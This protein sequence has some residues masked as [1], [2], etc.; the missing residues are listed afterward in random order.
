MQKRTFIPGS[1]WIYFKLYTGYKTADMIL[2]NELYKYVRKLLENDIIDKW[3][4]I[5][6]ADPDFHIRLRLHVKS[7]TAYN[8]IFQ[9]FMETFQQIVDDGYI[10]NIQCDT[11]QREIERYGVNSISFVEDLFFVDSEYTVQLLRQL[12]KENIE[13][14][15]WELALVM[16]DS[17]L[18]VFSYELLEKKELLIG[19]SENMKKEF[20]FTFRDANKQLNDKYRNCRKQ[21]ECVMSSKNET[22]KMNEIIYARMHD[23]IPIAKALIEMD[24]T[25]ELNVNLNDLLTSIIHMSMNRWFRSKNRL[26]ELVIY[27]FLSRYYSSE[28]AKLRFTIN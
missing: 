6:Y 14:C 5:R 11:Y 23:L 24:S 21:I 2:T 15:Q 26:Y 25:G 18:A 3:F 17:L 13:E 19:M 27:D 12:N 8:Y 4:F 22:L 1:E 10:W 9:K 20:G 28:W 7:T 16:I